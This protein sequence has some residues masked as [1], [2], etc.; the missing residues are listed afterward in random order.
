MV[1]PIVPD[2]RRRR[3]PEPVMAFFGGGTT[4][5]VLCVGLLAFK[6][7]RSS[8]GARCNRYE[9]YLYRRSD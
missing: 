6:F 2:T 9:A 1:P 3:E 5:A 7:A 4:R 8:H